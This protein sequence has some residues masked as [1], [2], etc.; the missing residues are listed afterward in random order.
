MIRVI[1]DDCDC[2]DHGLVVSY[3]L[4]NTEMMIIIIMI[5]NYTILIQFIH[6]L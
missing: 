4:D 3:D 6:M 1:L 2:D 5:I